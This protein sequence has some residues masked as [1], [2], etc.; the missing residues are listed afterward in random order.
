MPMLELQVLFKAPGGKG[1]GK[2]KGS[3]AMVW[4]DSELGRPG[5]AIRRVI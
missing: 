4:T 1:K 5:V 3:D 2:G